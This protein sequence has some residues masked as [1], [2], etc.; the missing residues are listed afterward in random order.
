MKKLLLL[1]IIPFLS[2]GQEGCMDENACNYNPDATEDDGSCTYPEVP[3]V[4]TNQNTG[5]ITYSYPLYGYD[6]DGN[7]LLPQNMCS[8]E[9]IEYDLLFVIDGCW[10]TGDPY[11]PWNEP[12]FWI[13]PVTESYLFY[14]TNCEINSITNCGCLDANDDGWCDDINLL[15]CTD[16]PACNFN[17]SAI[18]DDGSCDY[19]CC[20]LIEYDFST[21]GASCNSNNGA[22]NINISG[23]TPEYNTILGDLDGEIF[24][25]QTGSEVLFENLNPGFY[26]FAVFDSEG[27]MTAEQEVFFEIFDNCNCDE[28]DVEIT[29]ESCGEGGGFYL[30]SEVTN[31]AWPIEYS[32][33]SGS[34]MP[35]IIAYPNNYY[36]TVIDANG[37]SSTA[38]LSDNEMLMFQCGCTDENACN[39]DSWATHNNGSCDYSCLCDTVFVEIVVTEYIDCDTGLPCSSGMAE[40]IEK[41]KTDGKLYNLLGQEVFRR[42]GIYIEGGEIKYRF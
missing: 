11:N 38:F 15:G 7:C 3:F 9:E 39:Y 2:F 20:D 30:Y 18:Q 35:N 23:G 33:S 16:W 10:W 6:C 19:V 21:I 27:C 34:Q 17:P 14:P 24:S 28:L 4:N 25:E 32:W 31:A 37:C 1:L 13:Y 40:I 22:I 42:E 29:V 41:S 36:L 26:Y 5:E 12:P 8:C